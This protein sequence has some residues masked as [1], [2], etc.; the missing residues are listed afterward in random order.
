MISSS[1]QQWVKHGNQHIDFGKPL[2]SL[3]YHYDKSMKLWSDFVKNRGS[4]NIRSYERSQLINGDV[5]E[6]FLGAVLAIKD[7]CSFVRPASGEINDRLGRTCFLYK[8]EANKHLSPDQAEVLATRL[9]NEC[10][11]LDKH[12]SWDGTIVSPSVRNNWMKEFAI[13]NQWIAE[14]FFSGHDQGLFSEIIANEKEDRDW[15]YPTMT[16]DEAKSISEKLGVALQF[17][18]I[19]NYEAVVAQSMKGMFADE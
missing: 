9:I 15:N 4:L 10:L 19:E 2:E 18:G 3:P 16:K 7:T 12:D 8:N 11:P 14:N 1:Y 17:D 6:D 5:V 13:G